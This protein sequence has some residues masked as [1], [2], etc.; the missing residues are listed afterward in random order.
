MMVVPR[1]H[2]FEADDPTVASMSEGVEAL[3]SLL[4][5]CHQF[6]IATVAPELNRFCRRCADSDAGQGDDLPEERVELHGHAVEEV[7]EHKLHE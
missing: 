1:P 6:R 5:H 2:D 3:T 7:V 4:E